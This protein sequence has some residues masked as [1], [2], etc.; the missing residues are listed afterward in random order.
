MSARHRGGRGGVARRSE[1]QF[2]TGKKSRGE[3]GKR[4]RGEGIVSRQA[5]QIPLVRN[6]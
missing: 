2:I 1:K 4:S 5:L 3:K 6:G